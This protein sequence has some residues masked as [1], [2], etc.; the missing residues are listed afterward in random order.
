MSV[1]IHRLASLHVTSHLA[2]FFLGA[3]N[4][5]DSSRAALTRLYLKFLREG[6]SQDPLCAL[7]LEISV[8]CCVVGERGN[9]AH[10]VRAQ[11]RQPAMLSGAFF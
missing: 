11:R 8:M 7:L 5:G 9:A 1:C 6:G 3:C 2:L 4:S 10:P